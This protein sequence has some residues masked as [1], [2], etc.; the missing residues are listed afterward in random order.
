VNGQN[1]RNGGRGC[2]GR[3]SPRAW[4]IG[5]YLSMVTDWPVRFSMIEPIF[6]PA[7]QNLYK[8]EK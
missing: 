4:A 5:I 1:H 7:H 8:L 2:A 6:V 3:A